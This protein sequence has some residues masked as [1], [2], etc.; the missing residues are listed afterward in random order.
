MSATLS[1][2]IPTWNR[3]E[4][5]V[6]CLESLAAQ[7][8]RADQIIVVDDGSADDTAAYVAREWPGVR[9]VRLERNSGFCVAV[10]AGIRVAAGDW[11]FLLNNDMTLEPDCLERLM[12]AADQGSAAMLAPLVLFHDDPDT[13]YSAGDR[14]RANGRPEAI[15][16]RQR[17]DVYQFPKMIFGVSGGAGLYKREVFDRVGPLDE[18]FVA[19]FEDSDLNFRARLAGFEA[20]FVREAI[21]Y[22][23]GSASLGGRTWWRARQCFRNHALLVVK[24]FPLSVFVA[25]FPSILRERLHQARRLVSSARTEFGLVRALAML[26]AAGFDTL[27]AMPHCLRERR[28]IQRARRISI[29]ELKRLMEDGESTD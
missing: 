20:Q 7:S 5:L 23:V 28:R 25:N 27:A 3:R 1:V 19:Y 16:F 8:R 12:E 2:I 17:L 10:N 29:V 6:E 13:I 14:Q 22:H 24:D 21:A 26:G 9:L 18:C 4:L 11:V 15:G